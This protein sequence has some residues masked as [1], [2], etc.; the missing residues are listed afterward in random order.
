MSKNKGFT[1]LEIMIAIGLLGVLTMLIGPTMSNMLKSNTR[2]RA[3]TK[4]DMSL[5]KTLEIIKRTARG[6]KTSNLA[7]TYDGVTTTSPI[8][9]YD[10]GETLVINKPTIVD[11]SADKYQDTF[12]KFRFDSIENELKVSSINTYTS[13]DFK[14]EETLAENID[15]IKFQYIQG[16]LTMK[17]IVTVFKGTKNEFTYTVRDSAVS[18]INMDIN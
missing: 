10:E 7:F 8:Q 1:L 3:I 14:N 12:I 11:G 9:V 13:D 5:G 17:I 16:I 6:A 15:N 18:R 4:I 2:I